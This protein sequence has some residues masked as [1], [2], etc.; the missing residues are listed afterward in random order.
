MTAPT[1]AAPPTISRLQPMSIQPGST[2]SVTVTGTNL[3]QLSD[4]WKNTP[5]D[6]KIAAQPEGNGTKADSVVVDLTTSPEAKPGIFGFRVATPEG[7]SKPNLMMIDNLPVVSATGQNT[8]FEN[9]QSVPFP[10]AVEGLCPAV[11]R[12]YYKINVTEA[13][14]IAVEV[15]AR[16]LGSLLDPIIYLYDA[17]GRTLSYADDSPGLQRDCQLEFNLPAAGDYVVEIRDIAYKGGATYPYHVRIGDFPLVHTAYPIQLAE[18]SES[19]VTLLGQIPDNDTTVTV[20]PE[21]GSAFY[22][23]TPD[24]ANGTSFLPVATTT[25]PVL[26]ETEPNQDAETANPLASES[27]YVFNGRLDEFRDVDQFKF[28]AKANQWYQVQAVSEKYGSPA[29]LVVSMYE[30][31]GSKLK[32]VDDTAGLESRFFQKTADA[33]EYRIEV[34]DLNRKGGANYTYSVLVEPV[35]TGFTLTAEE[36]VLNIP[37]TGTAAITVKAERYGWNEAIEI[38]AVDLPAGYTS[39]R[40]I[41]GPGR[42]EVVLTISGSGETETGK[43]IPLKIVGKVKSGETELVE[44]ATVSSAWKLHLNNM[45]TLTDQFTESLVLGAEPA[46]PYRVRFEPAEIVLGPNLSATVKVIAERNEGFTEEIALALTPAADKNG[47]PANVTA[48]VKPIV[49]D[50]T[51]AIVTITGTEKAGLGEF[52]IAIQST[53]KKDKLTFTQPLPGLNLIF[54]SAL[55]ATAILEKTEA[56]KTEVVP[57]KLTIKRNPALTG[58][59]TYTMT[60]LP[61]GYTVPSGTIAADASEAVVELTV[62]ETAVPVDLSKL[63]FTIEAKQ[64]EKV[65]KAETAPFTLKVIE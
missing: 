63:T 30:P 27:G 25:Y 58:E 56:R 19:T 53:L 39:H 62:P 61:E 50:Q 7:V 10:T 40:T 18:G 22:L 49:K 23:T 12:H 34:R 43:I 60:N 33:G 5:G 26:N 64:G 16:R 14:R 38:A 4:V 55:T 28:N 54:E 44:T 42:N 47:L 45:T 2:T 29:D 52:T 65:F 1:S 37:Q 13:R 36:T 35:Q 9:A 32:E 11:A 20:T 21:A 31:S 17:S 15:Y 51:E 46:L 41:M 59:V 8:N 6:W 24:Y 57:V 3:A 48:D